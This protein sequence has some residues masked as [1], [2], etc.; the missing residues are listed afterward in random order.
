MTGTIYLMSLMVILTTTIS[1]LSQTDPQQWFSIYL[2]PKNIK[3]NQTG[4]IELKKLKPVG[5]PFIH[6]DDIYSYNQDTHKFRVYP[7]IVEKINKLQTKLNQRTF[8]VFIGDEAI[9]T[10]GFWL[11]SSSQSFNDVIINPLHIDQASSTIRLELGYQTEKPFTDNDL[12]ADKRVLK[13]FAQVGKLYEDLKVAGKCKKIETT[14]KRRASLIFT[15]EIT[16]IIKGRFDQKEVRFEFYFDDVEN[17][18]LRADL[19]KKGISIFQNGTYGFDKDKEFILNLEKQT[20]VSSPH[21]H[22]LNWTLK[23]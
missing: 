23:K 8:A 12:R 1:T 13:A 15:F 2:L 17:R 20:H 3:S 4:K 7:E 22:L 21:Y 19:S 16:V 11:S 10:G 9:Y 6:Q 14:G 18:K 5:K